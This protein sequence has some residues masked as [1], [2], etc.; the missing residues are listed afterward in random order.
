MES[1]AA[2]PRTLNSL[3]GGSVSDF[4]RQDAKNAFCHFDRRE[5]S[6]LDPSQSLGMTGLGPVTWRALRP[7]DVAQDMLC[8]SYTSCWW[9][10]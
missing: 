2:S 7:F 10:L 5:K 1:R 4:T 3:K 6:L 9:S 8:V